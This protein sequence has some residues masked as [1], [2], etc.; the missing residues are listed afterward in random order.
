M[1]MPN[2]SIVIMIDA[3]TDTT[4]SKICSPLPVK[5]WLSEEH[6]HKSQLRQ[7][8]KD[9]TFFRAAAFLA[10]AMT[11]FQPRLS[12]SSSAERHSSWLSQDSTLLPTLYSKEA[13]L[14][15]IGSM[16][17]L[18]LF[19]SLQMAEV[20]NTC[21]DGTDCTSSEVSRDKTLR[22]EHW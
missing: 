6:K 11:R 13:Q 15:Q 17:L 2:A 12:F 14:L 9:N 16:R 7:T 5:T 3:S 8:E 1:S 22:F 18:S 10:Y 20:Q 4:P 19:S 21:N